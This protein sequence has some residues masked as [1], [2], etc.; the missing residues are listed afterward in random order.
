[1]L[2]VKLFRLRFFSLIKK[3]LFIEHSPRQAWT[4][5]SFYLSDFACGEVPHLDESVH[6]ASHQVL[7]IR[8]ESGTFHVG[9]LAKL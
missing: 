1:M 3:S 2:Q 6:R 7:A 8:G 9:F 4:G 5:V